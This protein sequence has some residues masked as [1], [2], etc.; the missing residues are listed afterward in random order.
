MKHWQAA[1]ELFL[2][3]RTLGA[4]EWEGF[5][6]RE[7]AADSALV[8]DVLSLLRNE[9]QAA[10]F[11][12][13]ELRLRQVVSDSAPPAPPQIVV[14]GYRILAELGRGGMGVVYLAEQARPRRLVAL[15]LIRPERTSPGLLT[16]FEREIEVL[17][18][19]QHPGIAQIYQAGTHEGALG[20]Q[21]Y[22][23][24][25][26]VAGRSI[27]RHAEEKRLDDF[28]RLELLARACD[29]IQHAWERGVVH[30]DLKPANILVASSRDPGDPVGQP[31]V[32]DFGVARLLGEGESESRLTLP[33][34]PLGTL[35]Y[36]SPEQLRGESG[37]PD[38]RADVYSLGVIGYELLA[39]NP[40]FDPD[41]SSLPEIARTLEQMDPPPLPR[42]DPS[43]GAGASAAI[44]RA[45]EKEPERR[46]PNAGELAREL[47]GPGLR[48]QTAGPGLREERTPKKRPGVPPFAM[49]L[50]A[51]AVFLV[52]LLWKPWRGAG[53]RH[54]P[55]PASS[56]L[57]DLPAGPAT[58]SLEQDLLFLLDRAM[59]AEDS[60]P[61][62]AFAA[63]TRLGDFYLEHHR[64][65]S[66]EALFREALGASIHLHGLHDPETQ[67][68][69]IRE[70][71][72]LAGLESWDDAAALLKEGIE[73]LVSSG[74][75]GD[76]WIPP[77]K[78]RLK[79]LPR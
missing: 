39:G 70:G 13:G 16:R 72:A 46:Y 50:A 74:H 54:A 38:P 24:M 77:A 78:A 32:L 20:P 19:F 69:R 14:D 30:R 56:R 27:T 5:L 34:F 44:F 9:K 4:G 47:R 21:P 79:K 23:S 51:S 73:G 49:L 55:I 63:R 17:G 35:P 28:Q 59:E 57:G 58:E 75:S 71:L 6:R 2:K 67:R 64:F 8:E 66:A 48:L 37:A 1:K 53:T 40:P 36:M 68:I 41:R 60:R 26:L 12:E 18:R 31:K 11:L 15:K 61:T 3:A 25:E 29:A 45:M 76:P 62:E 65:H 42:L 33:G 43:L 7:C 22:L 10:G 52:V